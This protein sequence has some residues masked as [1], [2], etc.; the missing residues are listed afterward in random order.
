MVSEETKLFEY[1]ISF[2][3]TC[4]FLYT[5]LRN[6]WGTY[7]SVNKILPIFII[8]NVLDTYIGNHF[9]EDM[10]MF[11]HH[12]FAILLCTYVYTFNEFSNTQYT[13]S[14]WLCMA[15]ITTF[16]NCVRYFF[17]DTSYKSL[18]DKTFG[19]SFL[20][21]RPLTVIKMYEPSMETGGFIMYFWSI[22]GMLNTYW[23][24]LIIKLFLKEKTE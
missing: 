23:C 18:L 2:Y 15:E 5:N 13:F 3:N 1:T 24:V 11:L 20:I 12:I 19:A 10:S 4:V 9:H 8:Y 21:I 7:D 16:F 14:Y 22:Y 6:G 17:K